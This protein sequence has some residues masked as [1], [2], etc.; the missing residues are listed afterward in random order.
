MLCFYRLG[1]FVLTGLS[2]MRFRRF[3][4]KLDTSPL[5]GTSMASEKADI[6]GDEEETSNKKKTK[7]G[8]AKKRKLND[9]DDGGTTPVKTEDEHDV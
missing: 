8:G 3:K 9:A 7:K 6:P 2:A 4:D 1:L 5:K